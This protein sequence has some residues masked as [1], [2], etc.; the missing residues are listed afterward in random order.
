MPTAQVAPPFLGT[1]AR[2]PPALRGPRAASRAKSRFVKGPQAPALPPR[3]R[4]GRQP[5]PPELARWQHAVRP[6]GVVLPT[7]TDTPVRLLLLPSPTCTYPK[8]VKISRSSVESPNAQRAGRPH[9]AYHGV[10]GAGQLCHLPE[11]VAAESSSDAAA[12]SSWTLATNAPVGC[13]TQRVSST[14]WVHRGTS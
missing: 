9:C 5:R 8:S 7:T 2:P 1:S 4:M 13:L 14:G 12:S 6:S 10:H 3:K 11:G